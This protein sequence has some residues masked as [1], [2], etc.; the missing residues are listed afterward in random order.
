[1]GRYSGSLWGEVWLNG[2][3]SLRIVVGLVIAKWFIICGVRYTVVVFNI[4]SVAPWP[5]GRCGMDHD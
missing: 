3:N 4:L 1:M 5:S 2:S